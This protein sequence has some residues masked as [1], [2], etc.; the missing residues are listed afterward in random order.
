MTLVDV[1]AVGNPKD[2]ELSCRWGL[3]S[4]NETMRS[5]SAEVRRLPYPLAETEKQA[6]ASGMPNPDKMIAKL[7]KASY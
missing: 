6:L 3:L 7:T 1:S 4:W 2:G 5:W